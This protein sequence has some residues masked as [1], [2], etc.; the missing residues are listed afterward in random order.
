MT[1]SAPLVSLRDIGKLYGKRW[2][3][4]HVNLDLSPGEIVGF[5]GP[6]GAGKT[7]LMRIMAGLSAATEGQ[8]TVLGS[9]M[10][11]KTLQTPLGIGLVLEQMGFVA[12][13]SGKKNLEM[14]A[15]LQKIASEET[16]VNTLQKVGLDPN[17]KRPVRTYSLGMRQRLC[18]AQALMEK[19]KLLLLDE[20]TNGLDPAGIVDLRKLLTEVAAEGT[21]I[22]VASHLLTE[23]ERICHRV[24]LVRAGEI[25]KDLDL[26]QHGPSK[27]RLVVANEKSA[28]VVLR[29]E[30][31]AERIQSESEGPTFLLEPKASL[32][33]LVR[34]L[35][36]WDV[37]VEEVAVEKQSL[38]KEFLTLFR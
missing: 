1:D 23:V 28:E 7:T 3:L 13:L 21:A 26:R 18:L 22:F 5:I 12:H 17:D 29:S 27:I 25:L 33:D 24:L 15:A 35:V 4:R 8:A 9:T 2:A 10:G 20:P 6:N 16:I 32:P 14:L 31:G 30:F 36:K 11:G 37:D 38:E 34:T 19:P